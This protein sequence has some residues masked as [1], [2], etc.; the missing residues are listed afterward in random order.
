MHLSFLQAC[1]C[2]L[3]T[4][5]QSAASAR[6]RC[7][8]WRRRA[9]HCPIVLLKDAHCTRSHRHVCRA[10]KDTQWHCW[11]LLSLPDLPRCPQRLCLSRVSPNDKLRLRQPAQEGFNRFII[12]STHF[13]RKS[14]QLEM[15]AA[16]FWGKI[17]G[18]FVCLFVL[19]AATE[20]QEGVRPPP[21]PLGGRRQRHTASFP[22][23]F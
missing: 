13:S 20:A 17:N 16:Q 2:P 7:D 22:P 19:P 21:P 9:L 14:L 4:A 3:A 23:L 15:F 18:M 10:D 6:W 5:P 1:P 12:V 11:A 8:F